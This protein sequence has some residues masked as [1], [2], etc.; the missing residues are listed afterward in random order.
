[1][2]LR[3]KVP[4]IK[5]YS[6]KTPLAGI[7]IGPEVWTTIYQ[8]GMARLTYNLQVHIIDDFEMQVTHVIRGSNIL[9]ARLNIYR[10]YEALKI[11]PPILAHATHYGYQGK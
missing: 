5:R 9:P 3:F 2:P 7:V 6:W 1:M 11:T 4:E 10:F 8:S